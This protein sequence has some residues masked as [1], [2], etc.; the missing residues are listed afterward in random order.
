MTIEEI[1]AKLPK[2][3]CQGK[4]QDFCTSVGMT[5]LEFGRIAAYIG[6]R[7]NWKYK[8]YEGADPI[9][10][11]GPSG[12]LYR[13]RCPMLTRQG[14]CKVY[15]VRPLICRLW[16][17]TERMRCPFGCIPDRY[18]TQ[19]EATE[20]WRMMDDLEEQ[21]AGELH[22]KIYSKPTMNTA[23]QATDGDPVRYKSAR[24]AIGG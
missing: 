2:I 8:K 16:G 14:K 4:C 20:I 5:E 23:R 15:P 17:L 7:P 6:Y 11:V 9:A 10:G 24:H 21:R 13:L 19:E 3:E 12:L 1:Y 22:D 18:L